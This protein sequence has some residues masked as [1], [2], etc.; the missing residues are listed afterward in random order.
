VESP[1]LSVLISSEPEEE[2]FVMPNFVGTP[3]A[4]ATARIEKAGLNARTNPGP[5]PGA[6]MI[7]RQFPAPGQKVTADTPIQ[8]DVGTL[9][10][11]PAA[12]IVQQP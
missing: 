12:P 9:P 3:L 4:D 7:I 8:L 6:N 5:T 11:P 1:K 2:T 10:S